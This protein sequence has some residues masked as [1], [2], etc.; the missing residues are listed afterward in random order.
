MNKIKTLG[1]SALAG[2]LVALSA[3]AGDLSVSG[4]ANISYTSKEKAQAA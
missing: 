4:S 3:Q 2:S 1:I